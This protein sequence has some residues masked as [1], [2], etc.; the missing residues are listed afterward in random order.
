MAKKGQVR[1]GGMIGIILI[2]SGLFFSFNFILSDFENQYKSTNVSDQPTVE[3]KENVSKDLI[4]NRSTFE[5]TFPTVENT[6]QESTSEGG[7]LTLGDTSIASVFLSFI[8]S[9][10]DVLSLGMQQLTAMV[11]F[12]GL[13]AFLGSLAGMGLIIWFLLKLVEQYRRYP[14]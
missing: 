10:P 9:I 14:T 5:E 3:D 7:F 12:I 2:I 1:I 4:I 8:G 6:S 11:E 13:P